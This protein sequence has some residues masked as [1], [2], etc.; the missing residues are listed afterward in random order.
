MIERRNTFTALVAMSNSKRLCM[1]ANS[2]KPFYVPENHNYLFR[3]FRRFKYD[4]FQ[5]F[6][7]WGWSCPCFYS[8]LSVVLVLLLLRKSPLRCFLFYFA[9]LLKLILNLIAGSAA[10]LFAMSFLLIML[11][12]LI[13]F[14]ELRVF[15]HFSAVH[16]YLNVNASW[17]VW[18]SSNIVPRLKLMEFYIF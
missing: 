16:C 1:L 2:A 3:L 5:Y 6:W 14:V 4:W 17:I 13:D 18:V 11:S 9:V 8:F 7:L 12:L 15:M 10:L